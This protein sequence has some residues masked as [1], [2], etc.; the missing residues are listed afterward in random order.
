MP[1]EKRFAA[2]AGLSYLLLI[3]VYLLYWSHVEFF[4]DDWILTKAFREA[5][6]D[7]WAGAA[8]FVARAAH[9]E[10]LGKFRF[11][12]LAIVFAFLVTWLGNYAAQ[13]NFAVLLGAH[14]AS[15][16]L[17]C[18]ALRRLGIA[19]GLSFLAGTFYLLAPTAHFGLLTYFTV[20]HFV[21]G[22][23]WTML[24]LWL[25]AR[26]AGAAAL[27]C[28]AVVGLFSGEQ[29]ILLLLGLP[30]L[31]AGCLEGSLDRARLRAIAATWIALA[32]A[33]GGYLLWINRAPVA[34]TGLR[35]RYDWSWTTP[36]NNAALIYRE[37]KQLSGIMPEALFR[38]RPE[39][40]DMVL[41]L[42][43]AALVASLLWRW[44]SLGPRRI[45]WWRI[46][47]FALAG[48]L[49]AYGP[50]LWISGV[51]S[52]FRYHYAS[53]PFLG[54]AL[55]TVCWIFDGGGRRAALPAVLGGALAGFFTLNAAADLRQCWIPQSRH[56]R[57]L[58]ASLR[59][60]KNVAPGDI[61]I[62]AGTPYEIGAAQHFTMHSSLT[63]NPYAEWAT[64]V[65]PLQVGFALLDQHHK[66]VLEQRDRRP[67]VSPA[68]LERA[69]LLAWS[70][71]GDFRQRHWVAQETQPG[72]F[73]ML[74]LKGAA[75]RQPPAQGEDIY[76]VQPAR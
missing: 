11:Y 62:V 49:L 46:S 23:L 54:L 26:G 21:L 41:A 28:C 69:H 57:A 66:L 53:S 31:A 44:R 6:R 27:A 34:E 64:G 12:W 33:A 22:T 45:A 7:G 17:L 35:W 36:L 2:L 8:G 37:M 1:T 38:I 4:L 72:K 15:A 60:L 25:F 58:D 13:V 74:P 48:A 19:S 68:D 20:P 9:N 50:V 43:A 29:A 61:V 32:A 71:S 70:P 14:A 3:G 40:V 75:G 18:L 30:L 67:V 63:A 59:A 65:A 24:V 73:L 39:P 55:A 42:S 10:V 47:M 52:Q 56:H 51:D 76:I 16:W 5:A